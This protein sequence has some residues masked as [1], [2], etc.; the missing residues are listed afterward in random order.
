M[1]GQTVHGTKHFAPG[2]TVY[3]HGV[4]SGDG[5]ERA[6]VTGRHRD[7]QGL[8]TLITSTA[9]LVRWRAEYLEDPAAVYHLQR[10]RGYQGSGDRAQWIAD[11]ATAMNARVARR[12]A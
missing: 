6:Y 4:H 8:C 10:P 7:T 11:T 9:R 2:Q 3:V 12:E 5:F 1:K